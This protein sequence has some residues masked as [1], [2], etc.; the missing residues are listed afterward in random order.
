[1][2]V[3]RVLL[4]LSILISALSVPSFVRE[5]MFPGMTD[6]CIKKTMDAAS[7]TLILSTEVDVVDGVLAKLLIME[8]FE[9]V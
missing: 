9:L 4:D 7:E 2:C 3:G 1:M 8:G 5:V 6:G